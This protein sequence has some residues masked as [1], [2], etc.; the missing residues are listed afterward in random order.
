[1]CLHEASSKAPDIC[2]PRMNN[3]STMSL[4]KKPT[5]S[6]STPDSMDSSPKEPTR[7]CSP[8]PTAW[9]KKSITKARARWITSTVAITRRSWVQ[10]SARPCPE[11]NTRS[12][13]PARNKNP[14]AHATGQSSHH[15]FGIL[16]RFRFFS[17]LVNLRKHG[18]VSSSLHTQI[19][20]RAPSRRFGPRCSF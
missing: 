11:R 2:C 1:M 20:A 9:A 8:T 17:I 5:S 14:H 3:P 4:E 10:A 16:V 6:P 12:L 7:D 19:L 18:S 15:S 13:H